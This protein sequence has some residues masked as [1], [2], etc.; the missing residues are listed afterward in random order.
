M[1]PQH[2]HEVLMALQGGRVVDLWNLRPG[3]LGRDDLARP[4]SRINRFA[5]RTPEPWSVAAHCAVATAVAMELGASANVQAAVLMHDAHEVFLGDLPTPARDFAGLQSRPIG[6]SMVRSCFD[7]AKRRIDQ[8]I[9]AAWGVEFLP[10]RA[11]VEAIDL[12]MTE[13]EM[14][15][16]LGWKGP[17]RSD[18]D[19][20]A[21]A[22]GMLIAA[23]S[24]GLEDALTAEISWVTCLDTLICRGALRDPAAPVAA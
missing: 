6:P 4:L 10:H 16:M 9:E 15:T 11:S 5:G 18:P 1:R 8:A 20:Y 12:A 22:V 21:K 3:E 23:A 2:A 14:V 13:A 7:L 19:I 17:L 24:E